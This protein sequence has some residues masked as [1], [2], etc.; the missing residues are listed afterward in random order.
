MSEPPR[1]ILIQPSRGFRFLDVR[2]LYAYRDL[3]G[4]LVW[5][6][7]VTRYKQT[8]LGPLWHILQPLLTTVIFTVVFSIVAKLPTDG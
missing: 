4:L 6:D 2:E 5:R 8:L 7:F 1:E 3:L